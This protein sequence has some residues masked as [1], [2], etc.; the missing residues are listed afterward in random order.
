[1][2]KEIINTTRF[3]IAIV[4]FHYEAWRSILFQQ[5]NQRVD[6][7]ND[8]HNHL[9]VSKNRITRLKSWLY[10]LVSAFTNTTHTTYTRVS[11]IIPLRS[12]ESGFSIRIYTKELATKLLCLI[13]LYLFVYQIICTTAAVD[14]TGKGSY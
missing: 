10:D 7:S 8:I 14:T 11:V 3:N 13:S 5:A 12:T 6:Y 1:M 2:H 4:Y 9:E